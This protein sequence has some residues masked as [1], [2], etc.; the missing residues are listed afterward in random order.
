LKITVNKTNTIAMNERQ[1]YELKQ[2]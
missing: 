2:W 1:I